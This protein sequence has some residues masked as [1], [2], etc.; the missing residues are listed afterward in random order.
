MRHGL[1]RFCAFLRGSYYPVNTTLSIPAVG[2][3]VSQTVLSLKLTWIFNILGS[4]FVICLERVM[5]CPHHPDRITGIQS[6]GAGKI[7]RSALRAE[8]LARQE[9]N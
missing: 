7:R 8:R 2:Q 4:F 3:V 6:S 1:S 9:A 5:A